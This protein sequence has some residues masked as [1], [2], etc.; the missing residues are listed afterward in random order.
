MFDVLS[1]AAL[2]SDLLRSDDEL[3]STSRS[4]IDL[5]GRLEWV[6]LSELV[7]VAKC[8]SLCHVILDQ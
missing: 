3:S 7:S 5:K 6:N 2:K 4:E 1:T 8:F